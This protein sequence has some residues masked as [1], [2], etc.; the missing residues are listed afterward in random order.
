MTPLLVPRFLAAARGAVERGAVVLARTDFAHGA[1]GAVGLW[2]HDH[3]AWVLAELLDSVLAPMDPPVIGPD[4]A[5]APTAVLG[6]RVTIGARVRVGPGT[7]IGNPGF[8]WATGPSGAL[9]A[10]PQLAGVVIDDDVSIGPLCTID[11]GTLAATRIRRGAKLDAHVHV[12]HNGDVGAGSIIRSSVRPRR[13]GNDW[14]RSS[15]RRS[16]RNR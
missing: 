16:S 12:G 6:P 1:P 9:R 3:A 7:V 13:F 15:H 5:I 4:C 11:A 10:V 14:R 2:A 8:G